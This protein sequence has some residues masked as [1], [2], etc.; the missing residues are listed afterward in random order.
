MAKKPM[1]QAV[2]TTFSSIRDMGYQQ[3]R[4]IDK[5]AAYAI[6][7]RDNIK[8]IETG[9]ISDTDRAELSCGY[10]SRFAENHP[11]QIYM[12]ESDQYIPVDKAV[13]GKE[14]LTIGIDYAMGF[15]T[16]DFGRMKSTRPNLHGIIGAIRNEF[17]KYRHLCLKTLISAVKSLSAKTRER[18]ETK[19][20][21][22]YVKET[23]DGF[24][25]RN[26]TARSRGDATS[27]SDALMNKAIDA[28]NAVIIAG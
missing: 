1:Q 22:A 15:T 18:G 7:A 23:L 6:Y 19:L 20:V 13:D 12:V 26:K 16:S 5:G 8:G 4:H 14:C 2:E 9:E 24:V 3:A 27:V 11:S 17:S 10:Q 28:F 21:A 25:K